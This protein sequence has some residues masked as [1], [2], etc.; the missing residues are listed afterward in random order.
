VFPF[1]TA[2]LHPRP[3]APAFSASHFACTRRARRSQ[4]RVTC[5]P[6]LNLLR[7]HGLAAAVEAST[8]GGL[9]HPDRPSVALG[10]RRH[11]HARPSSLPVCQRRRQ[12]Q[13][14][15]QTLPSYQPN[16]SLPDTPTAY[17]SSLP[18]TLAPHGSAA[19]SS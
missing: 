15:R 18:S 19:R 2:P 10:D 13:H 6:N 11:D 12:H 4:F 5:S 1:T 8:T 7:M 9:G 14:R 17:S 16:L 3:A